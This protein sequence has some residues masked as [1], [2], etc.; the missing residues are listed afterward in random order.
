MYVLEDFISIVVRTYLFKALGALL[1]T[2]CIYVAAQ[3]SAKAR[4]AIEEGL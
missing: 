4:F 3:W 2:H 1:D